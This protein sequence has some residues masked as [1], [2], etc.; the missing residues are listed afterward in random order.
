MSYKCVWTIDDS[1]CNGE[2]T[3]EKMFDEQL[4]IPICAKHLNQHKRIISLHESGE[5]IEY[6][7]NNNKYLE[8]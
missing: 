3:I 2:V 8:E 4:S 1:D 6:I 5:D 7:L